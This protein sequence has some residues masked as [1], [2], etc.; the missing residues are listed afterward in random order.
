MKLTHFIFSVLV[1]LAGYFLAGKALA[2]VRTAKVHSQQEL[3]QHLQNLAQ[4]ESPLLYLSEPGRERFVEGMMWTDSGIAGFSFF[5]LELELTEQQAFSVLELF[6]LETFISS[7][8]NFI[9]AAED[10]PGKDDFLAGMYA[11]HQLISADDTGKEQSQ[12][13]ACIDSIVQSHLASLE[14]LHKNQLHQL[15][16]ILSAGLSSG[17]ARRYAAYYEKTLHVTTDPPEQHHIESLLHFFWVERD[18]A[19]LFSLAESFDLTDYVK[20][21]YMIENEKSLQLG[22]EQQTMTLNEGLLRTVNKESLFDKDF[23]VVVVSS[24]GCG[25]SRALYG[26]YEEAVGRVPEL[27]NHFSWFISQASSATPAELFSLKDSYP[28]IDFEIVAFNHEWSEYLDLSQYPLI[29]TVS[30]G[31]VRLAVTGWSAQ[32]NTADLIDLVPAQIAN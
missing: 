23:H 26:D 6:G 25:F 30:A 32:N 16:N 13:D 10:Y 29:Y 2:D 4:N 7:L 5:P 22:D 19:Q 15:R 17:E 11:L 31:E 3:H 24:P 18:F 1:C 27:A 12:A 20:H 14:D 8:S 28:L 9:P 21:N